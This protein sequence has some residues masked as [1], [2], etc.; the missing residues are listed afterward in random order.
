MSPPLLDGAACVDVITVGCE[1]AV[2]R[3]A[4][5]IGAALSPSLRAHACA[6]RGHTGN[7]A[8]AYATCRFGPGVM[9]STLHHVIAVW[10]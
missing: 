2:H 1:L 10:P 3:V 9:Q 8:R 6:P 7:R 4:W 5:W